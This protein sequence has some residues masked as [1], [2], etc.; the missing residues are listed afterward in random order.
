MQIALFSFVVLFLLIASGG[1]LLFYRQSMSRR[2]ADVVSAQPKKADLLDTIHQTGSFLSG[3]VERLN[4]V[5]PKSEA[6]ISLVKKRFVRAGFR[7]ETAFRVFY[8]TKVL[9]PLLLCI[10]VVASGLA[11]T[12]PF[13]A[14]AVALGVGFIIPDFWLGRRVAQR[15]KQIRRALPDTLDFLVICIEAGLS[16]D[17]ATAR[18]AEEM[19]IS[20]PAI[21]DELDI[22]VL[23]QRAGRARSDAWK[24]FAERSDVDSVR[25]LASVLAQA[26]VLGTSVTKTLRIHSETLR[27]KRRQQVEEQAAKTSVKLVFPLVLLIFPSLFVVVL[28]P[29]ALIMAESFKTYFPH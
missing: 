2:V 18:T 12:N 1:M 29:E 4:R 10:A 15:Q 13:F 9:I 17:H 8:G 7:E 22:V 21:S 5:L 26:E 24:Q 25:T 19:R 28:G 11:T 16:L 20:H 3:L 23:E 6:E 27:T 14:Y